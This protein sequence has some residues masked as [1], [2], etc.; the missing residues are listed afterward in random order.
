MSYFH[1]L[2]H[3][4]SVVNYIVISS[5]IHLSFKSIL[6][7]FQRLGYFLIIFYL[8][9]N[10]TVIREHTVY[11][12]SSLM[13]V[14]TLLCGPLSGQ[15]CTLEKDVHFISIDCQFFYINIMLFKNSILS[16]I[17]FSLCLFCQILRGMSES[18]TIIVVLS[19]SPFT[20]VNF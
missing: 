20:S 5:L 6:L 15:F 4:Y 9:H 13:F 12:F 7:N 10:Y 19:I 11:Y 14:E 8:G 17:F 16:L 2:L 1:Y 18:S 3:Y